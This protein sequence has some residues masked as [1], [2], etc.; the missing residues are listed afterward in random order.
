MAGTSSITLNPGAGGDVV[1]AEDLGGGIKTTVSKLHTGANGID[2]GPVTAANPLYVAQASQPLPTGASTEATLQAILAGL[3]PAPDAFSRLRVSSPTTLFDSLQ[4]YGD[5]PLIWENALTGTGSVSNL[6]NE[7]SVQLSTGGTAAGARVIRQSK[8]YHRYQPGKSQLV[9]VTFVLAAATDGVRQRVGYFDASNGIYLEVDGSTVSF[10]R[11]SN[12]SGTPVNIAFAKADWN[13]DRMDG[14][15]PSGVDL[16]LTRDQILVIDL[17]WL[18]VGRVRVGFDVGG[19]IY[20]AHEFRHANI[21]SSVYMTTACLPIRFE[22][23]NTGT[24]AAPASIKHICAAVISEGGFDEQTGYQFSANV[25]TTAPAVTTRR[26]VLSLRARA[27]GRNGVRNTG[28]ILIRDVEAVPNSANGFLW[29]LVL[30]ATLGGTP[31]W[32]PANAAYSIAEYDVAGTT[33][34]GG[35]VLD[36]GYVT[37]GTNVRGALTTALARRIPLVYSGLGDVQD[38]L[39]LVCTSLNATANPLASMTWQ[40]IW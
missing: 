40:E 39:S 31:S 5:N 22:L 16:D 28:Q 25:G 17:Q 15:G 10:V 14:L 26:A 19:V 4:Q 12:A 3:P 36:S 23:E 34:S 18:G 27:T 9:F 20:Y 30:N 7:S 38:V 8:A 24:A 21:L 29:E 32:T 33:V 37:S 11:R 2:G 13:L 6:L 35:I 1:L